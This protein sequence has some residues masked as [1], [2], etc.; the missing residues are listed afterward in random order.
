MKRTAENDDSVA[1]VVTE[2][3]QPT[4]KFKSSET[5]S[6]GKHISEFEVMQAYRQLQGDITKG[7]VRALRGGDIDITT[8][9]LET[10]DKLFEYIKQKKNNNL[11]AEDSRAIAGITELA[12]ITVRN[13][14]LGEIKGLTNIDDIMSYCK[15][16][17]LQ[18]HFKQNNITETKNGFDSTNHGDDADDADDD[19]EE[20]NIQNNVDNGESFKNRKIDELKKSTLKQD[21]LNQFQTYDSFYQFNWFK[22]GSLFNGLSKMPVVTDNLIGPFAIEKKVKVKVIRKRNVDVVGE[23]VKPDR[24][25]AKDLVDNDEQT[26]PEQ[27]KRCFKILS[28]K[29]GT[30]DSISLFKF[31]IDPNSF[32][33]SVEN[34]FYTSFLIKAG[35]IV[36]E[37]DE[38]NGYPIIRIKNKPKGKDKEERN[39]QKHKNSHAEEHHIIFQMDIPTWSKLIKKFNITSSYLET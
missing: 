11:F 13:L 21:Y 28:K 39:I 18:E 24:P 29:L 6:E 20:E 5:S 19:D 37:E 2:Q 8:D 35:K 31:V 7:R 12:E 1:D 30:E 3:Q 25:S 15:R 4:K 26:T 32:P 9:T 34:L 27:V 10:V 23:L 36:M 22:L 33:K 17:M 38:N 14:K 16:Y